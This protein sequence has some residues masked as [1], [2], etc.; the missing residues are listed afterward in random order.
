MF[1]TSIDVGLYPNP[2]VSEFNVFIAAPEGFLFDMVITELSG[3]NIYSQNRIPGN[4]VVPVTPQVSKG[5]YIVRI[6]SA[7]KK[8]A[9]MKI[10][11]S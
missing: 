1:T 5:Y 10:V 11:K 8:I 2:F 4:T 9:T 3:K 6:F 7:G